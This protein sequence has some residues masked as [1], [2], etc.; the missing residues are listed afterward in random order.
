MILQCIQSGLFPFPVT[1][2]KLFV[3]KVLFAEKLFDCF[4]WL[5]AYANPILCTLFVNRELVFALLGYWLVS[6]D[7]LD[8]RAITRFS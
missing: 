1:P 6:S 3:V 4:G 2:V 5:C 7:F 8:C